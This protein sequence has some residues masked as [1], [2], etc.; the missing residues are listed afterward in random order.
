M[1]GD[2]VAIGHVDAHWGELLRLIISIR[3]GT[4]TASAMLRR[5]SAYPR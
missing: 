4:A 2:P 3:S 1:S 5:F